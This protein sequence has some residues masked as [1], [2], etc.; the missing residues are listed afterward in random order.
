MQVSRNAALG[1][2][3][4]A[5]R[6]SVIFQSSHASMSPASSNPRRMSYLGQ[7]TVNGAHDRSSSFVSSSPNP[8]T[9][10][11]NNNHSHNNNCNNNNNSVDGRIGLGLTIVDPLFASGQG[12]SAGGGPSAR[13]LPSRGQQYQ[14]HRHTIMGTTSTASLAHLSN[15]QQAVSPSSG[16]QT[17]GNRPFSMQFAAAVSQARR[18]SLV[19]HG[20]QESLIKQ[21]TQLATAVVAAAAAAGDV[22]TDSNQPVGGHP[23]HPLHLQI[24]QQALQQRRVS[25]NLTGLPPTPK[26]SFIPSFSGPLEYRLPN[27]RWVQSMF[28]FNGQ[29]LVCV[30]NGNSCPSWNLVIIDAPAIIYADMPQQPDNGSSSGGGGG[31]AALRRGSTVS[32]ALGF[33]LGKDTTGGSASMDARRMSILG[34]GSG[35][36]GSSGGGMGHKIS[37]KAKQVAAQPKQWFNSLSR[38]VSTKLA[39]AKRAI[40]EPLHL[41]ARSSAS[42]P[43]SSPMKDKIASKRRSIFGGIGRSN[44]MSKSRSNDSEGSTTSTL[45]ANM[46]AIAAAAA[47]G[48]MHGGYTDYDQDQLALAGIPSNIGITIARNPYVGNNTAFKPA[49]ISQHILTAPN[50]GSI[51][52]LVD[53]LGNPRMLRGKDMADRDRWLFAFNMAW[54]VSKPS[55]APSPTVYPA[56][57]ASATTTT[58]TTA[59]ISSTAA[60]AIGASGYYAY[61]GGV[62]I[63]NAALIPVSLPM[64]YPGGTNVRRYSS[65]PDGYGQGIVDIPTRTI[66]PSMADMSRRNKRVSTAP[67]SQHQQQHQQQHQLDHGRYPHSPLAHQKSPSPVQHYTVNRSHQ[68][69]QQQQQ[70]RYSQNYV[71]PSIG[72]HTNYSISHDTSSTVVATAA[73]VCGGP[74]GATPATSGMVSPQPMHMLQQSSSSPPMTLARQQQYQNALYTSF[75]LPAAAKGAGQ[76]N[77]VAGNPSTETLAAG[78]NSGYNHRRISSLGSYSSPNLPATIG[79]SAAVGGGGASSLLAAESPASCG[80]S[81]VASPQPLALTKAALSPGVL[82]KINVA[83]ARQSGLMRSNSTNITHTGDFQ[84]RRPRPETIMITPQPSEGYRS[85]CSISSGKSGAMS[86]STTSRDVSSQYYHHQQQQQQQQ[87]A[88]QQKATRPR[89]ASHYGVLSFASPTNAASNSNSNGSRNPMNRYSFIGTTMSGNSNMNSHSRRHHVEDEDIDDEDATNSTSPTN[90]STDSLGLYAFANSQVVEPRRR[91]DS[92]VRSTSIVMY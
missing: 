10:N 33:G 63:D 50:P 64:A 72:S 85:S 11:N 56:T 83:S 74:G 26:S 70:R 89:P 30:G 90:A 67:L 81:L 42:E 46:A 54:R 65:I 69:Q 88:R 17:S 52:V 49:K 51:I 39:S 44:S 23:A 48:T 82:S 75:A 86:P 31:L 14:S 34:G 53:Q 77:R 79:T 73:D 57:T 18:H 5:N 37:A 45:N 61:G 1:Q 40:T 92:I 66:T 12:V 59:I 38:A 36:T 29:K 7:V 32:I 24:S 76:S 84:T 41:S 9:T 3:N 71:Q 13:Q 80:S 55:Q 35:V 21:D 20:M 6:R 22:D 16:T 58:T 27:G 87:Q 78:K 2:A 25:R 4:A 8:I 68:Q 15:Q 62:N 43:T 47:P 19:V 91:S 60:N 28:T